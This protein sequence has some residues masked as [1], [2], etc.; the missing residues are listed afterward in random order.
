[1]FS[2]TRKILLFLNI[3]MF[4]LLGA[5]FVSATARAS[6]YVSPTSGS[7]TVGEV[8]YV[9]AMINTDGTPINASQTVINFTA[10][11]LKA[12][13]VSKTGSIFTL[14]P[15]DAIYSNSEG[16]ISFA[17]GLPTPGYNGDAGKAIT[18][19]FQAKAV[20]EAKVSFGES[21][22][23][24]NDSRGTNIF[25]LSA[26]G[27]YSINP[28]GQI[29]SGPELPPLP[30]VS[31]P[32]HP[33]PD[34][35]YSNNNP[36]LQ[37]QLPRGVS[38]VSTIFNQDFVFDV[39]SNSEGFFDSKSFSS[40]KDGIWYFHIKFKNE[41]GWGDIT[42]FRVQI[43]AT[44]PNPFEIKSDNE[45][46]STNPRPLLYFKAEDEASGINH[47]DVKIGDGEVFSLVDTQTN[48]FRVPHQD[49]GMR[50][51]KV[52]AVDKAGN[53]TLSTTEIKID[54]IT[55][56]TISVCPGSFVSGEEVLHLEGK[57]PANQT[58][59]LYLD[60][61]SKTVKIWE[62]PIDGNGNWSLEDEGVFKSG[63]YRIIA[64]TKDGRGAISNP[65]N[66][67][68]VK[69][70]FSG[71]SIFSWV[72]SYL[73]IIRI[74]ITLFI[75]LLAVLVLAFIKTRKEK[76]YLERE[77][78]DLKVKFYKE[79]NELK[80]DIEEQLASYRRLKSE[81]SLSDEEKEMVERLLK[82]LDDVERVLRRELG[83]IEKIYK[84]T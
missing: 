80:E 41:A 1:M 43:D 53:S 68:Q 32:T 28:G 54:S 30:K 21:S 12:V 62:I 44:A 55:S 18:I 25:T 24:A 36:K 17:A 10:D 31:S 58:V 37:W 39:P 61:N 48:P 26:G 13:S 7:F 45:G 81:R 29:P 23:L 22:I 34:Q 6:F 84:K 20:G 19:G 51:I 73:V 74:T 75:V 69:F 49:P 72:I 5:S 77:T 35:W 11:K 3:L 65:S 47:Y 42:R 38:G 79:Y 63:D 9:K 46:D 57:A 2:K 82:D 59:L 27:T 64:R 40:V 70:V 50:G 8:F 15:E 66:E 76:N 16:T 52:T 67:C 4:G 83:D 56:P 33:N 71:I 60:R 78:E 14:W